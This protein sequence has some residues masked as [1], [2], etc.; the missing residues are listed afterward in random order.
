MSTLSKINSIFYK[1][2]KIK[3]AFLVVAI[4]FGAT[5]EM[6]CLAILS[7]II[8]ILLDSSAINTN[9]YLQKLYAFLNF[10]KVESF[11]ALLAFLVASLYVFRSCYTLILNKIRFN[12][13]GKT[14]MAFSNRLLKKIIR[15]PYIFHTGHNIAEFQKTIITDVNEMFSV[16]N[17]ICQFLAD[18]FT[19]AF[20]LIF[21][22]T[23]SP[24]MS[25]CI[26][27]AALICLSIYF[28]VFRS[29]IK[30]SGQINRK[31]QIAM[32]K[33][34][35]QALGG[36]KEVKVLRNEK[37]FE[38]E[39]KH[40][41][42]QF[43]T[44]F[45]RFQFLNS[46]PQLYIEAF[47]FGSAFIVLAFIFLSGIDAA[48]MLPLLS[49]FVFAA[50]RILP[51]LSRLANQVNT[52]IYYRPSI[53]AVYS[54]LY[55]EYTEFNYLSNPD[56]K[57]NYASLDIE[58]IGI[59]YKYPQA[60]DQVL[61][62]ISFTIPDK[63]SVALVGTS[64]AGKTTLADIILG[65]LIPQNGAIFYNG[66][67]I[68]MNPGEWS[69]HIGYI[70]QQIYILDESIRQ[71]IAFG[72]EKKEIDDD[73]I[74]HV[75]ELAQ[76]KEF[77]LSFPEKLDTIVGDR[78]IRLSGGQR[79]R[80]GI[81]RAL[82]RDPS[83]LVL[84]EA[85]SSL[86]S[87]TEKAVMEAIQSFQGSKTLIIVAHRLSTIEHCDIVFRLDSKKIIKQDNQL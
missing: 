70:P 13:I 19:S 40:N 1:D 68:H 75:L 58:V 24:L 39:F 41:S 35:N 80:I 16:I 79:Q 17:N 65:I 27:I 12:F 45:K 85:T 54:H 63:S 34:I 86:D 38:N 3:F 5:I 78:G 69:K 72:I 81:A 18:S 82:Y 74:W 2:V 62:N 25:L 73:I 21:L 37:Y 15:R 49:V 56:I 29:K 22:F 76:L 20:I 55:D 44:A 46:I 87:D 43:I 10:N 11:L 71:N 53:N 48:N 9:D 4:I 64:G 66:L 61:E 36:I 30:K 26:I 51:T 50:F 52:I 6:V 84:D 83:I 31:K 7:P 57:P 14:R 77:V 33:S 23:E 42:D 28:L 47:C 32:I 60:T 8:A 67:N 59:T